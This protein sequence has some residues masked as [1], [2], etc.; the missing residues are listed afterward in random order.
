[1]YVERRA[2]RNTHI[3]SATRVAARGVLSSTVA[4]S[5]ILATIRGA[6]VAEV[7]TLMPTADRLIRH[8]PTDVR[9]IVIDS[10]C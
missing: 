2:R 1:M 10:T 9:S 5:M 8:V 7:F 6:P 4:V 3:F